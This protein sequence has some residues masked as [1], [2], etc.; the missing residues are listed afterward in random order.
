MHMYSDESIFD[1]S[2]RGSAWVTRLP[3]EYYHD[4]CMQHPFHSGHGSE[5]A[6]G[7]IGHNWK[8]PL[9]LLEGAGA[10][11]VAAVMEQVLELVVAAAFCG[12]LGYNASP[13]AQFVEDQAP[14]HGTKKRLVE[15][16][17]TLG[18]PLH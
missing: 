12:L 10:K 15:V 4:D 5:M 7:A 2:K 3:Y 6:S 9:I 1:T 18:I 17:S 13:E 11:G 14:I 8:S 16:K